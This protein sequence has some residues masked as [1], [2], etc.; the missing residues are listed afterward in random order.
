MFYMSLLHESGEDC[1]LALWVDFLLTI[2]SYSLQEKYG[3]V[4][5]VHVDAHT[6]TNSEMGGC[7]IMHGTPF[8]RA[9]EEGLIEPSRVVQ[10]GLRGTGFDLDELKWGQDKVSTC[11]VKTFEE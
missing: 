5:L 7:P 9:V 1:V 6:D 2:F 3:S 11:D 8:Y 4:G 10:I